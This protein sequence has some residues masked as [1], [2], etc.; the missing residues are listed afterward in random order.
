LLKRF[1]A[2]RWRVAFF[3]GPIHRPSTLANSWVMLFR[4]A[5]IQHGRQSSTLKIGS[6]QPSA[7]D[8][9]RR[10]MTRQLGAAVNR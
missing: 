4:S 3:V 5:Q 2:A 7:F 9:G 1:G 6:S 10:L 8:D